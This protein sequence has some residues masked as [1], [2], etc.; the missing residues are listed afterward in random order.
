M[1][2]EVLT[3]NGQPRRNGIYRKAEIPNSKHQIPNK[4][5]NSKAKFQKVAARLG[6]RTPY[7]N[8][9]WILIFGFWICLEF[10][11]WNLGFPRS[12]VGAWNLGFLIAAC[13]S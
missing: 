4:S 1:V 6:F 2:L 10:G 12:G 13:C 11:A 8:L 5:K 7:L 9:F 3:M